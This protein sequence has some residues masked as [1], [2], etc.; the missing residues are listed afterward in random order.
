[1][2]GQVH[3]QG[4]LTL[5]STQMQTQTQK[6]KQTKRGYEKS[7]SLQL[8]NVSVQNNNELQRKYRENTYIAGVAMAGPTMNGCSCEISEMLEGGAFRD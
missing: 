7:T 5:C 1:M 8:P 4:Y 2:C 6:N 3:D